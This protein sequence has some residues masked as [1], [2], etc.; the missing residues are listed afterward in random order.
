MWTLG[1][2]WLQYCCGLF[3]IWTARKMH[4]FQGYFSTTFQDQSDFPPS[5][6]WNFQ[7]K[8]ATTFQEAWE[9][10]QK[11]APRSRPCL[12]NL[13]SCQAWRVGTW[14]CG[15]NPASCSAAETCSHR[16]AHDIHNHRVLCSHRTA[17]NIHNHRVLQIH[18]Q[19][20]LPQP[21]KTFYF[22]AI[23]TIDY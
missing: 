22:L 17:H 10:S 8:K 18:H 20:R 23:L 9:R 6:S 5:R 1:D 14:T 13:R 4:D 16:T 21:V 12:E 15:C 2:D 19:L 7:G 11:N 3:S